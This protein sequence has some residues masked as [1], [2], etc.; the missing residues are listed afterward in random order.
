MSFTTGTHALFD[1]FKLCKDKR[2]RHFV[3]IPLVIS[4]VLYFGLIICAWHFFGEFTHWMETQIA[5]WIKW[6]AWLLWII[7]FIAL[8]LV[9]AYTFTFIANLIAA[10]FNNFLSGK[11]QWILT[12]K[13]PAE[14]SWWDVIKSIGPTMKREL[15]KLAYYL[16]RAIGFLILYLIPFVNAAA[17]VAWFGFN[18]WMMALQYLDYP[19][20]N[21]EQSFPQL[22]KH[23]R[24]NRGSSYGFGL[25]V[26]IGT[27]IPVVN[28]F[29]IPAAV[30]GATKLWLEVSES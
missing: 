15:K 5:H 25:T 12:G 16:P 30:C 9:L 7:F 4:I 3:I 10:P 6:L 14:T 27:L 19:A 8:Y 1:G 2:L 22:L 29:V 11:A 13:I 20:E 28:F 24:K 17:S 26:M 21:N 23:A 18:S